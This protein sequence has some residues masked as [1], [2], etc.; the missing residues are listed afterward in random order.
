V[1]PRYVKSQING[2]VYLPLATVSALRLR[3]SEN[4]KVSV[5]KVIYTLVQIR[6]RQFAGDFFSDINDT[7]GGDRGKPGRIAAIHPK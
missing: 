5:V 6:G 7:Y 4:I 2:Q 1:I 3:F